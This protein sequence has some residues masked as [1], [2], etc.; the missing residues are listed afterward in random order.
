[1]GRIVKP[2]GRGMIMAY[3]RNSVVYCV[4][5][6]YWLIV[7]GKLLRGYNFKTIQDFCT[8]GYRHRYM[9]KRRL[10]N[11]LATNSLTV[12]RFIVTQ[13]AKKFCL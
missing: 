4:H 8:N 3:H 10:R 2:D 7:R 11:I 12:H 1:M 6:L 9:T 13:Y 5:G